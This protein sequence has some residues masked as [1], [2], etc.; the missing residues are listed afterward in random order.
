LVKSNPGFVVDAVELDAAD[1]EVAPA[2]EDEAAFAREAVG[3][4]A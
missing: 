3:P 4:A 1:P 2:E